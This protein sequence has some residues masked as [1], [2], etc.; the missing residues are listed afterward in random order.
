MTTFRI[1][2]V[3]GMTLRMWGKNLA[4]VV[5]IT[6]LLHLPLVLW[7]LS[8][9]AHEMLLGQL[10][11][12]ECDTGL[13][14]LPINLA[15][16][17]LLAYGVVAK[18]EG[19]PLSLGGWLMSGVTR[20]VTAVI[21]VI[22]VSSCIGGITLTIM[23]MAIPFGVHS[24][25]IIALVLGSLSTLY[26]CALWYAAGPVCV[27]EAT[28]SLAALGRGRALTKGHRLAI[29]GFLILWMIVTRG[30]WLLELVL[31]FD[32]TGGPSK[33]A[34]YLYVDVVRQVLVGSLG[35]VMAGV[36][37]YF[38]RAEKEGTSPRQLATVFE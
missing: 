13:V 7:E 25:P 3:L 16:S 23:A 20:F 12:R 34:T 33:V 32:R 24:G 6:A 36:T 29:V 30:L 26:L 5:L 11:R 8:G 10:I 28:G 1:G 22:L 21:T 27:I 17:A 35:G 31:T 37:Y 15:V 9:A 19:R 4:S 14:A 2:R 38:L 18:L